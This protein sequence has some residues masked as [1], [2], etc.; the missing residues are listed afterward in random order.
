VIVD[1]HSHSHESD[2]S[3]APQALADFMLERGVEAFSIT[4]HD[5][6]SAYDSLTVAPGV[7][8]VRGLEINTTY[9]GNEVHILGYAMRSSDTALDALLASNRAARD[10]RAR[11]MVERLR[12]AGYAITYDDV[13]R[14]GAASKALGRPHVAKAL[15][16]S[17]AIPHVDYA[18]R[19]LLSY[20]KPAFA[21]SE[22]VTPADAV[23]AIKAAGGVAVLAH[24]GRLRD[25]RVIE[26]AVNWGIDGLEV[27]YPRHDRSDVARL[28]ASAIRHGLL[29]TAGADFHDIRYHTAGV[30]MEVE[31]ADIQPFLERVL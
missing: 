24:P 11:K 13:V 2:G 3:L 20:G 19:H 21:A 4:D 29:M 17:G 23:A 25:A 14:E 9:A 15:M 12:A 1:F 6:V 27:F 31:E 5:T 16:R 30:G 18:F 22:H 26:A 10:A 8:M 28:R 7:R